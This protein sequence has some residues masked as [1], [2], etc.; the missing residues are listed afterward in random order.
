MDVKYVFIVLDVCL[1]LENELAHC[2][3]EERL[4]KVPHVECKF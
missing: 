1:V 4:K 2:K 3:N